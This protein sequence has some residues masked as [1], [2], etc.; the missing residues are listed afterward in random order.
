MKKEELRFKGQVIALLAVI[1]LFASISYAKYS[2]GTG[3]PNTP[4]QLANITDLMTL[5]YD[6][7]D[8]NKCF[9]MTA[10]INLA[11]HG[12]FNR[13]VI[14]PDTSSLNYF[15][16]TAFTGI[17]DGNGK[18]IINMRID[19]GG[20][21]NDY[22]GLFGQLLGSSA[23]I[24]NLGIENAIIIGGT[25]SGLVGGLC[26]DNNEGTISN[27]Y[28]VGSLSCIATL[29]GL[30]GTNTGTISNCYTGGSV[31]GIDGIVSRGL[32]GLCG[33]NAGTISNSHST[34]Y[35]SGHDELG[36]LCGFNYSG[37][38]SNCYASGSVSGVYDLGGLCGYN[39]GTISNCYASGSL[40]G[41]RYIGGLCG[42][43]D[44]GTMSNSYA[45]GQ[46][47]GGVN[48]YYLGG[49]CGLNFSGTISNSYTTGPVSGNQYIGGFCGANSYSGTINKCFATGQVSG[50][51]YK[52]GFCGENESGPFISCFWDVNTSGMTYSAGGTGKT[53]TQMKT[54][55]TFTDGGWDFVWETVNGPNDVW[56]ICEGVSYPKLAWEYIIGDSDNNKTVDFV[57]FALIGDKWMEEDTNLYCGGTDL[58]GDGIVDFDDL[59]LFAQNWLE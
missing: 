52:G 48:S 29:G 8:Y 37:I 36:G 28:A 21:G 44:S 50:N 49:L 19:T 17:F 22:L 39:D 46:V 7:T 41:N 15:Q 43:S 40:S 9:I 57:D 4:Y 56:A 38:I 34:S 42:Y 53:T 59:D 26:G 14:A 2:G 1:A 20:Y 47:T 32:G 3:D 16:G 23:Q 10:D 51:Q 33:K 6:S 58:T 55:S 13:A 24:K 54:Q 5:A 27:C 30:C 12:V 18:K 35:V 11:S 25:D 31:L 45:T